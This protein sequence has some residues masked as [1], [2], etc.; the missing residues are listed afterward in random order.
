[1]PE[2]ATVASPDTEHRAAVLHML[3]SDH[4]EWCDVSRCTV[5]GSHGYVTHRSEEIVLRDAEYDVTAEVVHY[6]DIDDEAAAWLS[7]EIRDKLPNSGD[8]IQAGLQLTISGARSLCTQ[9]GALL[10]QL[11]AALD[12]GVAVLGVASHA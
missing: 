5:M 2:I 4:Y 12:D 10:A 6:A 11:P 8:P 3:A 1:M 7:L 9:L